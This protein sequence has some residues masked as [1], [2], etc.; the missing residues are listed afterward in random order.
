M[1]LPHR[2]SARQKKTFR[3]TRLKKSQASIAR[4]PTES[5]T[6]S[7]CNECVGERNHTILHAETQ[8]GSDEAQDYHWTIKYETLK[9]LGCDTILL[10]RT[11]TDSDSSSEQSVDLF[12]PTVFRRKPEW[13]S[14]LSGL[15]P[16]DTDKKFLPDLIHELY[17]CIQNDCRRSA[18]MAVR[19]LLE[20]VMID[21]VGDQKTFKDNIAA[22]QAKGFIL[23]P[24]R[25][26]LETA[27]E[28]GNATIHRAFKPSRQDLI[29]LVDIAENVVKSVYI[30]GHRAKKRADELKAL[31]KRI[32]PRK[33]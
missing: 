22:F 19:A 6:K 14:E 10:R 30:N 11:G 3:S 17:I 15:F 24:Q 31:K 5:T 20:Q 26:F 23:P 1:K 32:P 18:A 16:F 2:R 7:F 29:A 33:P 25:E 4:C 28:A 8:S 12:P 21:K 27:I 9:C 13:L